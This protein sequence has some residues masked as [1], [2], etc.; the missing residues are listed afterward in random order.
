MTTTI[1]LRAAVTAHDIHQ[2]LNE[3]P[4][5]VFVISNPEEQSEIP[6]STL[7]EVEVLL[8]E[9]LTEQQLQIA[10]RLRWIHSPT[11]YI[12]ELCLP[13]IH[14]QGNLIVTNTLSESA[15]QVGDFV[16]SAILGFARNLT[17]WEAATKE[18][19][20]FEQPEIIEK[21]WNIRGRTLLQ[22]GLGPAG[23]EIAKRAGIFDMKVIGVQDPPSFHHA[24]RRVYETKHLRSLL[25]HA[26]VV[27]FCPPSR[28]HIRQWLREEEVQLM[29]DGAILVI[30]CSAEAAAY[31]ELEFLAN[32]DKFRGVLIDLH[33]RKG[34]PTQSR[35]WKI[36]H[37]ILTP[38]IAELPDLQ[39]NQALRVFRRN[40]RQFAHGNYA[41][42]NR[43]EKETI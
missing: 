36:P 10:H 15:D 25:P 29:Q 7:Q 43:I 31:Q 37:L 24:C 11:A 30:I 8:T 5:Y 9:S 13:A 27:S 16:L 2:L 12:E 18:R 32:Y 22:V 19:T 40:L 34:I 35:L 23:G 14:K 28:A 3:F 17:G 38:G 41:D 42:M 1:L 21:L 33:I 6:Q 20:V 4:Q 39:K 26:D